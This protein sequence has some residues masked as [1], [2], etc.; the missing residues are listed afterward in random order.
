MQL[1]WLLI[2]SLGPT[3]LTF[4]GLGLSAADSRRPS[5]KMRGPAG[6]FVERA[7][8]E[9]G[10]PV[11]VDVVTAETPDAYWPN[12]QTIGISER[13]YGGTTPKDW[14]VAAHELGHA[15]NMRVHPAMSWLLPAGRLVATLCWRLCVGGL[16]AAAL[17]GEPVALAFALT[18]LVASLVGSVIVCADE[19]TASNRAAA[20]IRSTGVPAE[21]TARA[22]AAMRA[23]GSAY[24][25]GGVGQLL[26]LLSWPLLASAVAGEPGSL[27]SPSYL[28]I[29]LVLAMT[30]VVMLRAALAFWQV[31][32]PEPIPSELDLWALL[33]R[34][35]RWE[36]VCGVG[37][38]ATIAAMYPAI[39]G[40]SA[41]IATALAAAV[42]IGPVQALG[43][44]LVSLPIVV[45]RRVRG[46]KPAPTVR[47]L[48]PARDDVPEA[49][50]AMWAD[51]P[52]YLRATWLMPV[53]YLPLV[54][55]V[56]MRVL[57]V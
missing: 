43:A 27:R 41:A 26:V 38:V 24:V 35:A 30:P 53:A 2:V 42:A 15:Q 39:G 54:G 45:A 5:P 47:Y 6:P 7:I 22:V 48:K 50:I 49:M 44:A 46:E 11:R 36:S 33:G 19:I 52:W 32:R 17:F 9:L 40:P 31:V 28:G 51:P 20:L 37:M 8:R 21:A 1:G 3:L 12:A 57:W 29:W 34:E 18:A 55:V 4:A 23:A 56:A 14:A 25:L 10:L 13:T 16:L